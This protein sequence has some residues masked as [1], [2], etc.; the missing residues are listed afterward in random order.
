MYKISKIDIVGKVKK[1]EFETGQKGVTFFSNWP[2]FN[3]LAV[4]DEVNGDLARSDYK[5]KEGWIMN[6]FNKPSTFKK[7]GVTAA[8]KEAQTVRREDI[9]EA[10]D[11]KEESIRESA[12]LRDSALLT[13]AWS[14]GQGR[15]AEEMMVQYGEFRKMLQNQWEQPFV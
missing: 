1:A 4:G 9:R 6:E 2:T 10:Q 14:H 7:G 8:V 13:A 11:R 5:G 12:I 3:T 15:T